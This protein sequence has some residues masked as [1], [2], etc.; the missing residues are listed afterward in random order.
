MSSKVKYIIYYLVVNRKIREGQADVQVALRRHDG[1]VNRRCRGKLR[2][3]I[4]PRNL[5]WIRT[6]TQAHG[7]PIGGCDAKGITLEFGH[8]GFRRVAR[9]YMLHAQNWSL[10]AN[11]IDRG[12]P[13]W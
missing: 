12:P 9:G 4:L 10:R 3:K 6:G 2:R 1:E 13:I 5:C 11:W 8:S 7:E